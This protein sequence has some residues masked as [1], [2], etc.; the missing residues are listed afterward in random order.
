MRMTG[1]RLHCVLDDETVWAMPNNEM[2]ELEWRL[3][4]GTPTRTDHLLAAS[5][6]GCYRQMVLADTAK[7]RAEVVR[8]LRAA[9]SQS[10][11]GSEHG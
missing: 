9:T 6:L 8:G 7:R 11:A 4:Y 2:G 1:S 5:V 10:D 3:R